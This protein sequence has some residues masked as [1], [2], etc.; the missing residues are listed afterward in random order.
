MGRDTDI[1][2]KKRSALARGRFRHHFKRSQLPCITVY[3]ST[4][5]VVRLPP[6]DNLLFVPT[7]TGVPLRKNTH[8]FND[9]GFPSAVGTGQQVYITLRQVDRLRRVGAESLKD[10]ALNAHK[11]S[12]EVLE[13]RL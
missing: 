13:E 12:L 11:D 10:K 4:N 5:P 3:F 1:A 6:P 8:R 7:K 2:D 9:I